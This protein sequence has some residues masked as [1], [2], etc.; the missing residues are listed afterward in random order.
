[1]RVLLSYPKSG[2]TWVRFM[3]DSYL[4]RLHGLDCANVFDAENLLQNRLPIQWTHLS[5]AMVMRRAYWEMGPLN[6]NG[7][8][9]A[10]WALLIRNFRATLASAYFQARDRVK[11]FDGTPQQFVRDPRYGVIKLVTFYNQWEQLRPKLHRHTIVSYESLLRDTR[12]TFTQ[13]LDAL[14][15]EVR[16][17][18]AQQ[19]TAEA[20][21]EHMKALSVTPAYRGTVL[22]PIDPTRPETFKVR[23]GGD[24]AA[25]FDA[26]DLAYIDD[27]ADR[28]FLAKDDPIYRDCLGEPIRKT[29]TRAAG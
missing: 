2:R 23:G 18:L 14:Q 12:A 13:I 16:D 10:A 7:A 20:T 15:I 17:A 27:V 3:V 26:D 28:L 6:L 4:C 5:G 25:L 8:V 11:V 22:A 29:Q 1:M 21:F 24:E 19:V 9:N